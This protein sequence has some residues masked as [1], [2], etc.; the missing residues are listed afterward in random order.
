MPSVF[1]WCK[2]RQMIIPLLNKCWT[3]ATMKE[4]VQ[5]SVDDKEFLKLKRLEDIKVS[6]TLSNFPVLRIVEIE[7]LSLD[8]FE[9]KQAVSHVCH[10]TC[11]RSMESWKFWFWQSNRRNTYGL[12]WRQTLKPKSVQD[13]CYLWLF[14]TRFVN[15]QKRIGQS[16]VAMM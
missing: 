15:V 3:R 1:Y 7:E 14:S 6:L 2:I 5:S 16:V 12:N 8:V 10:R 13:H 11:R 4:V 9:I